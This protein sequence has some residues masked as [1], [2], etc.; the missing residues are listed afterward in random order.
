MPRIVDLLEELL[1]DYDESD[2]SDYY[3]D[4]YEDIDILDRFFERIM[5]NQNM[6]ESDGADY[7]YDYSDWEEKQENYDQEKKD[8]FYEI[9]VSESD[10]ENIDAE[11][12][13]DGFVDDAIQAAKNVAD[14]V[15]DQVGQT[16]DAVTNKV[17]GMVRAVT[18][19]DQ[20]DG[21]ESL[22]VDSTNLR[23]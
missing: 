13:E 3:Y 10:F 19:R 5:K 6:D 11:D 9:E 15:V 17:Q 2:Y 4:D 18:V 12:A 22:E 16:V 14:K 21:E 7:E 1:D 20:C 8:G 23:D